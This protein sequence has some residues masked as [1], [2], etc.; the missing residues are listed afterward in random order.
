MVFCDNSEKALRLM[1]EK[2]NHLKTIVIFDNVISQDAY[3]KA[4][5]KGIDLAPFNIAKA[6]GSFKPRNPHVN[7]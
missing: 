5:S 6:V 2:A 1:D 3:E 4:N 7:F